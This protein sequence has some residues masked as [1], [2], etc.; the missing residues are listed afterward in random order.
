MPPLGAAWSIVGKEERMERRME[1]LDFK[2]VE[3]GLLV[4][5]FRKIRFQV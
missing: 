1:F 5:L 3:L 4:I 2:R